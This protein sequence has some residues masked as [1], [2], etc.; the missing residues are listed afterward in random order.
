VR[1]PLQLAQQSSLICQTIRQIQA[2][3]SALE[4]STYQHSFPC[5]ERE[6]HLWTL[7]CCVAGGNKFCHRFVVVRDRNTHDYPM[8]LMIQVFIK[9]AEMK[10]RVNDD[11]SG[12]L[13]SSSLIIHQYSK[14]KLC[15]QTASSFTIATSSNCA[16]KSSLLTYS[17][18]VTSLSSHI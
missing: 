6:I 7:L 9:L 18:S 5:V 16:P 4:L 3:R 8:H 17:K 12:S 14:T 1:N 15:G 13:R 2:D 10:F 11:T